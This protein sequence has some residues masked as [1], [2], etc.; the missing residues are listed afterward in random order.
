MIKIENIKQL[1]TPS[2]NTVLTEMLEQYEIE[3]LEKAYKEASDTNGHVTEITVRD[4]LKSQKKETVKNDSK[5]SFFM[6]MGISISLIYSLIGII[7]FVYKEYAIRLNLFSNIGL[8]LTFVGLLLAFFFFMYGNLI[9]SFKNYKI[10]IKNEKE[11]IEMIFIKKWSE[12][13]SVTRNWLSHNQG[14]SYSNISIREIIQE[15]QTNVASIQDKKLIN[16][17]MIVRN[18][19]VHENCK[20]PNNELTA[21]INF[22]DK[23]I[24][25]MN[26]EI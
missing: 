6:N 25:K 10:S 16:E 15:L 23:M 13:E 3:V 5:I 12:L 21:Y 2:A 4:L 26:N 7:I 20:I 11:N 24:Q 14:E 9:K 19:I 1:L 17:M 22:L 18:K 8:T